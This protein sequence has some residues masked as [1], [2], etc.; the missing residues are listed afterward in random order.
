M[1]IHPGPTQSETLRAIGAFCAWRSDPGDSDR[2]FSL[3]TLLLKFVAAALLGNTL[4]MQNFVLC[5][6]TIKSESALQQDPQ[7]ICMHIKIREASEWKIFSLRVTLLQCLWYGTWH[8]L[9][10]S[11]FWMYSCFGQMNSK[12]LSWIHRN[13]KNC[14]GGG[15]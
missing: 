11:N 2:C 1:Q 4:K 7:M 5:F 3:K 13:V 12:L 14:Y 10:Y 6:R 8:G 9:Q 15:L